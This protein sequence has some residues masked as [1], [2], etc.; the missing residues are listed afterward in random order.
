M[1]YPSIKSL[2]QING[3]DR[4][5]AKAIRAVLRLGRSE[6][7][8]YESASRLENHSYNPQ[9]THTLK[10][11]ACNEIIGGYG[12]EGTEYPAGYWANCQAPPKYVEYINMGDT[13]EITLCR[14]VIRGKVSYRV[15]DW[16]T[17]VERFER[18]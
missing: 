11:E 6:A 17:I 16:G 18:N 13:Y 4:D 7:L 5:K 2:Q 8:R 14:V 1:N 9:A 15:S 10:L 3:I 12:V